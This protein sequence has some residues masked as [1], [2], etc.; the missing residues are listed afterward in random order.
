MK[1]R[2]NQPDPHFFG[3]GSLV[4]RQTHAYGDTRPASVCG[5][6][7]QW[8]H[9]SLRKLAYLSVVKVDGG[10]IDGLIAAVP[11]GDWR[12]LDLREGA[13]DRLALPDAV[14]RHDHPE[15]INVQIYHTRPG[16]VAPPTVRHPVLQSYLDTVV[17]GYLDVFGIEGAARFFQ[18]TDGWDSPVLDDR[19]QPIYSRA[20]ALSPKQ[21]LLVDG[22]LD[23][24]SVT[25]FWP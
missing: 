15:T 25:R 14:V 21:R 1:Q 4:N 3:Y 7:R 6:R 13:Y 5:W 19:R 23:D 24:L 2:K 18:S 16:I 17:L 10:E 12:A 8:Q 20:I 9:T 22:F 11:N